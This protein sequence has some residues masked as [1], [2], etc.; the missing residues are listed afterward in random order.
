[1]ALVIKNLP[2]NAGDIRDVGSMP[3]TEIFH[4]AS[5]GSGEENTAIILSCQSIVHFTLKSVRK[6]L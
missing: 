3:G 2:A 1:M 6:L 4:E 5:R